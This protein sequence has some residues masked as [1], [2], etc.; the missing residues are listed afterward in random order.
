METHWAI[1]LGTTNT[2][3]AKWWERTLSPLRWMSWW[4]MSRRGVPR[5]F[6]P[7]SISRTRPCDHRAASPGGQGILH[8]SDLATAWSVGRSFKKT[9]AR[10]SQ[11]AVAQLGSDSISARE[12][13]SV[14]MKELLIATAGLRATAYHSE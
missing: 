5:L 7:P 12:C 13:A 1:D 4:I 10:A 2:L 14:F 6:R 11:Q 8:A 3:I 9:L